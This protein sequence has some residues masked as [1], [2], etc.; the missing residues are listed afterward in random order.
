MAVEETRTD[1]VQSPDEKADIEKVE[2]VSEVSHTPKVL[3]NNLEDAV[4]ITWK[5]WAVI[6]VGRSWSQVYICALLIV[7][8]F[9]PQL[10]VFPSG[11]FRLL[12][13]SKASSQLFS[14]TQHLWPGI[15][16]HTPLE[17][18]LDFSSLAQ[19]QTS[20]VEGSFYFSETRAVALDSLLLLLHQVLC[21]S[22]PD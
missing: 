14:M 8:R 21:N 9:S 20:S 19:T 6:F 11:L 1:E 10:S 17:T 15:F 12:P 22:P 2:Q 13:P 3:D 7:I 5:T 4:E 18:H 16:P